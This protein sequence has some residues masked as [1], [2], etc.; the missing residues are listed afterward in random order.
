MRRGDTLVV[1]KL[2]RLGR[3]LKRGFPNSLLGILE[4]GNMSWS[5]KSKKLP[6]RS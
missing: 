2:D 1:W 4:A 3:E 6:T 5:E